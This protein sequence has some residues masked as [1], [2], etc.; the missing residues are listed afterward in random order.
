LEI[1]PSNVA[2]VVA[3]QPETRG[4]ECSER[5][6]NT[7]VRVEE[8]GECVADALLMSIEAVRNSESHRQTK[9]D[10]VGVGGVPAPA[11]AYKRP[12]L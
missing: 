11:A 6:R 7:T 5:S 12:L 8:I 9:K 2:A 1:S 10:I 4:R 3:V